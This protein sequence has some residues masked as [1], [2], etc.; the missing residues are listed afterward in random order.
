MGISENIST[1]E[2]DI[3]E[4]EQIS[5]RKFLNARSSDWAA[6][7][8]C[9]IRI[10]KVI[11]TWHISLKYTVFSFFEIK[12]IGVHFARKLQ[13]GESVYTKTWYNLPMDKPRTSNNPKSWPLLIPLNATRPRLSWT[14][15]W[16]LAICRC[17]SA[18]WLWL[19]DM[20][21]QLNT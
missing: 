3:E 9:N 16:G 21:T 12:N 10:V 11:W 13:I 6:L 20:L 14:R 17:L 5:Y 15:K 2:V 18:F 4:A 8:H 7:S 1:V 19:P